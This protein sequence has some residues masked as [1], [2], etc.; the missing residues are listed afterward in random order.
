MPSGGRD[1]KAVLVYADT[2]LKVFVLRRV[3]YWVG[4]V[5]ES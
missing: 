2:N 4:D 3:E 1:E 5:A